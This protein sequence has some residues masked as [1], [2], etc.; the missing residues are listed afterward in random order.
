M[1]PARRFLA[2]SLVSIAAALAAEPKTEVGEIN[3]AK[4]RI[5]VPANWNGGLVMYCHGYNPDPVAYDGDKKLSP[6]LA[7]FTDAGYALAQ[8]G[9]ATGGWAVQEA[10]VDTENLRR[11]FIN[12]YG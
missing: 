5:D 10:V 2:L 8:S 11:Y 3:G 1:T 7:V 9:Y 12:K 4:F 6:V